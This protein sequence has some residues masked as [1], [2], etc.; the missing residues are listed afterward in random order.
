MSLKKRTIVPDEGKSRSILQRNSQI[1]NMSLDLTPK[2]AVSFYNINSN[3][4]KESTIDEFL[5]PKVK[6]KK[7]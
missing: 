4:T 1:P 5:T 7:K 6:K 3:Q 2:K